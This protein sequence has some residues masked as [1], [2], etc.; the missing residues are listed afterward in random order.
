MGLRTYSDVEELRSEMGVVIGSSDW[1]VLDQD[2]FDRFAELTFA[3]H[4]SHIDRQ[5]SAEGPFGTTIA[6]G[7]LVLSL[8]PPLARR[9]FTIEGFSQ[10]LNYGFDKVRFI[11]PVVVDS[12]IR[13]SARV[14]DIHE[15]SAG[16]RVTTELVFEVDGF[17]RPACVAEMITSHRY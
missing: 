4:W 14:M 8:G 3:D 12:P 10:S 6:Q 9:I 13:V 11:A 15:E 7:M 2:H 17:D 1:L 5:R 16:I